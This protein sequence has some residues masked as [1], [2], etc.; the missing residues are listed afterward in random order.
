MEALM[1]EIEAARV[2]CPGLAELEPGDEAA[3]KGLFSRMSPES[4]YRRF[5]SP[6]SRVEQFTSAVLREDRY[7]RAAVAAVV[8]GEVVGVAQYSRVPGATAAG[9]GIM[10]AD[11][12]QRQGLGTRM[13]AAL[14]ARAA[15]RGIVDFEVDVQGDNFGALRL[16]QRVAPGLRLK[17]SA[18]IGE[19]S[20][21]IG[22]RS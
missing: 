10:V 3:V 15:A 17:F 9:L 21:S 16:L 2:G 7:E 4:L 22:G 11:D 18:G 5:F 6:I 12:W 20:F 8:N 13:L 1:V 19:G 14:A